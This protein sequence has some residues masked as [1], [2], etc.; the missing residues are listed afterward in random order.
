MRVLS[1]YLLAVLGGNEAPTAADISKILDA[2]GI[3]ADDAELTSVLASVEG[4]DL[5]ELIKEG[6]SGREGG[7][8]GRREGGRA[9]ERE[10]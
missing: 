8:E 10:T 6:G 1:A 9:R 2:V 4:K 3:K 5:D 7:R